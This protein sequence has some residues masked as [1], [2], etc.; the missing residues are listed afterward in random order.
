MD[1]NYFST[2]F[3]VYRYAEDLVVCVA[4]GVD[5]FDCVFPTRT[6]R[7]GNALTATGTLSLRQAK[8]KDDFR[9]IEEGCDCIACKSYTRAYLY[10]IVTKETVGCHLISIHNT[11]YQLRL[12]RQVR[13]SIIEDR[14]PQFIHKFFK[15]LFVEKSAYPEWAVN[16]LKSVNVDLIQGEEQ[17]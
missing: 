9:P 13:E 4:L 7:F 5:M 12:M 1:A 15:D 8:F 6:A 14:F 16:A 2:R 3:V 10:T 11:A 17:L